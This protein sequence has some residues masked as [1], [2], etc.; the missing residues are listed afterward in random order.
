MIQ[1]RCT[2]TRALTC[3]LLVLFAPVRLSALEGDLVR[4]WEFKTAA[5]AA[6]W[7][8]GNHLK[9]LKVE[10]GALRLTVTGPDAYLFAPPIEAPLDGCVVRVRMGSDHDGTSEVFWTTADAPGYGPDRSVSR[11]TPAP[12]APLPDGRGSAERRGADKGSSAKPADEAFDT[13]DFVLGSP[14]DAG[15][16]LTG[17]RLDPFNGSPTGT[18]SIAWVELRRLPAVLDVNLSAAAHL[19]EPGRAVTLK[20]AGRQLAGRSAEGPLTATLPDGSKLSGRVEQGAAS[21]QTEVKPDAPGVH[22]YRAAVAVADATAVYDLETSLLAGKGDTLPVAAT[23]GSDQVRLDFIAAAAGQ[24]VGAARWWVATAPG[25][26]KPAGWLLPLAEVA[27]LNDD[28]RVVRRQPALR[29]T[30]NFT[31]TVRLEGPLDDQGRLRATILF[32]IRSAASPHQLTVTTSVDAVGPVRLLD[33]SGPVLRV[34]RDPP[35]DPLDRHALFGGLE[36]LDP[37]WPS[38]SDRAVGE[39]FAK[40]W[41]PAPFKVTLPVMAVEAG[42][43]TSMMLWQPSAG[44]KVG[45]VGPW[46]TFASPNL[47]DGQAN[48][49]MKLSIPASMTLRRENE[50]LA[51]E[52]LV[53]EKPGPAGLWQYVLHAEANLPAAL[54]ARR[55]YELYSPPAPPPRPHND[56]ETYNLIARNFGETMWWPQDKGW[57][58]HWYLDKNSYFSPEIAAELIAHALLTGETKWIEQTGLQGK[59]VIDV[60]G[61]LAGRLTGDGE[62]KARIAA[63]RPDGTWPY[64][65]SKSASD[66]TRQLTQGK[67]DSLGEDGTTSLGTCVQAALPILRQA[68]LT[69]DPAC[70]EAGLKALSAMRGF[71][72]PRGAQVWEVHKD[73][74]DIRAAALAVEAFQIGYRITAD[75]RYLED[76]N[77]W[78]WT[79]AA[80]VYGW[81][82]PTDRQ[83][84]RMIASRDRNDP[85][86]AALPLSEGFQNPQRQVMPYATVPVLGPTCYVVNWFGVVVQWCGLE[87]AQHVIELDADRPDPLLRKIADGVLASG[88]Q[89][90]FDKPP[91]VGLYPDVWDVEHNTAQGAFIFPRFQLR[92]LQAQRRAPVWTRT[93]T[94][95]LRSDDGKTRWHV[96][97]W[98]PEPT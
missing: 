92:C 87:W 21:L 48:H 89:Q 3:G 46:P 58:H 4:R 67:Y 60:L 61:S 50:S 1:H 10:N 13:Y 85:H 57:R 91:W 55:W 33:C 26:W 20:I 83:E 63:M 76:A 93:W 88:L 11:P 40:R 34:D 68:E 51:R 14:A 79:G 69:G 70:V 29:V 28:G 45:E 22:R 65:N 80:F 86:R 16:K 82:V 23:M 42:G 7:A 71:R 49:L 96:S 36:F 37:G 44:E 98:G 62:A 2:T 17:F 77:Y 19:V 94:R 66:L 41:S 64:A 75:R 12:K 18:V 97:G 31:D 30:K 32:T 5:D 81:R 6:G 38:S 39:R 35:G 47:L 15:R 56:E 84:G 52:P 95:I 9:D 43:L 54:A 59:N 27:C 8:L 24:G 53:L 90:M 73:I 78:G 74:P 25:Q 72:V